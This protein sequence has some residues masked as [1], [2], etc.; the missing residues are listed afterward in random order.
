MTKIVYVV[1][2]LVWAL[3][4]HAQVPD[5]DA[6]TPEAAAMTPDAE[7]VRIDSERSNLEAG[8]NFESAACYKK[9]LVSRCLEDVKLR[10][11]DA[12]ADLRRQEITLNAFERKAKAAAQVKKTEE[13]SSPENQQQEADKR[14]AALKDYQLRTDREKQKNAARAEVQANE[15]NN[16]EAAAGRLKGQQEKI[17]ER[18]SKQATAAEQ[19]RKFNE[20][21]EKARERQAQHDRDQ[22]NQ[23]KPAPSLPI[24]E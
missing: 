16:S 17:I 4:V 5:A 8:F 1:L 10:R 6:A 19:L 12:L 15:L 3:G 11:R 2:T 23:T 24:P 7:R 20:R 18:N 9:F 13:K 21:Q 14:V 22:A